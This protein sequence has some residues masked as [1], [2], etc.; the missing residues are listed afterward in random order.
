MLL[1]HHHP[2]IQQQ[3]LGRVYFQQSEHAW[4]YFCHGRCLRGIR[5]RHHRYVESRQCPSH[6]GYR[7]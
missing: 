7:R 1:T 3:E 2:P 6:R 4:C 5:C